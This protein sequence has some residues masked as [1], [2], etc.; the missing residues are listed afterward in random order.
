MLEHF[1]F[2]ILIVSTY[3][4]L[5]ISWI[6]KCLNN[7]LLMFV[8]VNMAGQSMLDLWRTRSTERGL[9]PSTSVLIQSVTFHERSVLITRL[10]FLLSG[11][12]SEKRGNFEQENEFSD[13]GKNFPGNKFRFPFTFQNVTAN[14]L[15]SFLT[16]NTWEQSTDS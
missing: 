1:Y 15:S 2:I 6:I 9:S 3:Y 14:F 8:Y 16:F 12:A 10:I 7:F 11:Q 5:H 13:A 4:I